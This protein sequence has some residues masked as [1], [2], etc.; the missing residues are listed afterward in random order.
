MFVITNVD[1]L[2]HSSDI[3]LP[4]DVAREKV[5]LLE[6]LGAEVEKGVITDPKFAFGLRMLTRGEP[7]RPVSIVDKRHYVNLAR[8]RASEFGRQTIAS[9]SSS[10]PLGSQST[11]AE[12]LSDVP[13][14]LVSSQAAPS[15]ASHSNVFKDPVRGLFADQFENLSNMATHEDGTASEIWKQTSGVIDAFVSGAGTGGT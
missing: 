4:D 13:S 7:V 5:Q 11:T 14:F 6:A 10:T 2:H 1:F 8:I 15:A 9:T 12:T 3:V